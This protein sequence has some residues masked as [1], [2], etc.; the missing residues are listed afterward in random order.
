MQHNITI[1][2]TYS[3]VTENI[4][5]HITVSPYELGTD[6]PLYLLVP[7]AAGRH[8]VVELKVR[9]IIER[10]VLD[11]VETGCALEDCV[12]PFLAQNLTA[13]L[14]TPW[15]IKGQE[16]W[17]Y[18][19]SAGGVTKELFIQAV[20]VEMM[21]YELESGVR[22]SKGYKSIITPSAVDSILR[23]FS[24][25]QHYG[26]HFFYPTVVMGGA[27]PLLLTLFTTNEQNDD[28]RHGRV[29]FMMDKATSSELV[30][31]QETP[32]NPHLALML[33]GEEFTAWLTQTF[34]TEYLTLAF[35][36]PPYPVVYVYDGYNNRYEVKTAEYALNV[37]NLLSASS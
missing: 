10:A 16:F 26:Q 20:L 33:F 36:E 21:G 24:F 34:Y 14:G 17:S 3:D 5:T 22:S 28:G 23:G 29:Y 8:S 1:E 7:D 32:F 25:P 9:G 31:L 4:Y 18:G 35:D 2:T 6:R 15:N 13:V 19:A 30:G 12:E 11:A 37:F 27:F